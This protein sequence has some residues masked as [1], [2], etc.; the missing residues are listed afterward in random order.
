MSKRDLGSVSGHLPQRLRVHFAAALRNFCEHLVQILQEL[1]KGTNLFRG[2]MASGL[3]PL[4]P[5]PLNRR[6]HR[7]AIFCCICNKSSSSPVIAAAP[8]PALNL[9]KSAKLCV[10][11]PRGNPVVVPLRLSRRLCRLCRRRRRPD[12]TSR[13]LHFSSIPA[14]RLVGIGVRHEQA[15]LHLRNRHGSRAI[16]TA[17]SN[18]LAFDS[19]R[20]TGGVC[21]FI[22]RRAHG[23][24]A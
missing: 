7:C 2:N 17:R 5:F 11:S 14:A 21:I 20:R 10:F 23:L 18:Q 16:F 6:F 15:F 24:A 1:L 4:R 9:A 8:C 19:P 22:S 13:A 3:Q 12:S